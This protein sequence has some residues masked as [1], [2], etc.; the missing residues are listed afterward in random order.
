[1]A[2]SLKKICIIIMV[3]LTAS[4]SDAD[5]TYYEISGN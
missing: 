2:F 4:C 1:M 3:L 5:E